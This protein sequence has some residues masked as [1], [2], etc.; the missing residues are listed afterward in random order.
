MKVLS[1]VVA[2][3][4]LSHAALAQTW[5]GG[6]R[7]FSY[8][9]VM[10]NQTTGRAISGMHDVLVE[11]YT[12]AGTAIYQETQSNISFFNGT[13]DLVIGDRYQA[14]N[15]LPEV[16]TFAEPY[17]VQLTIDPGTANEVKFVR[18][19]VLSAPY[20]LNS[21]RVNG[22][23]VSTSPVAGKIF[24][25]PMTNGKIDPSFLPSA[26]ASVQAVNTVGPDNIGAISLKGSGNITITNDVANHTV[27]IGETTSTPGASATM[28]AVGT[29]AQRPG[30]PSQ[31]MIRFNTTTNKF[32]GYDGTS[33]V[34]LN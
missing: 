31:G 19:Q 1:L 12:K 4:V 14:T 9:G 32:E 22:I 21:Q 28:V 5:N 30:S 27:T 23:E 33:W 8:Q 16:I 7:L 29:T 24:P 6:P 10:L 25:I 18:R 11:L 3:I 13:F 34:N 15:E 17:W 20:A 2:I 26:S